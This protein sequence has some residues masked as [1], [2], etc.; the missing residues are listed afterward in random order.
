M[1]AF[2]LFQEIPRPYLDPRTLKSK[3]LKLSAPLHP[4]RVH[5]LSEEE[6][7]E[8]TQRF[9]ELNAAYLVLR[10]PWNRLNLLLELE[11]GSKPKDIQK[12]PP[13]TMD[14]FVEVGQFCRDL[15]AY[16]LARNPA[17]TSSLLKAVTICAQGKWLAKLQTIRAQVEAKATSTLA[18]LQKLDAEWMATTN[19]KSLLERLEN[20]ARLFSYFTRWSQQLGDRRILLQIG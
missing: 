12:I 5:H 8:A 1:N 3:F 14:L 7:R 19:H 13:G 10:E 4:D 2:D 20:I 18:E 11:T 16:L 6:K 9:S 15:D 17:E